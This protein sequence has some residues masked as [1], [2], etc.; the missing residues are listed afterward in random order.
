MGRA[1]LALT[2]GVARSVRAIRPNGLEGFLIQERHCRANLS[3]R[4]VTALE[5]VVFY[6]GLLY[7]VQGAL[8]FQPFYRRDGTPLL[9]HRKRQTGI[10]PAAVN[11]HGTGA[12][13]PVITA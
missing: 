4:A 13:L 2:R 3:R 7:R 8:L 10:D 12:A 9:H 6:E 1:D 5:G 11:K